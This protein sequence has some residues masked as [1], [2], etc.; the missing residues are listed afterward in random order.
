MELLAKNGSGVRKSDAQK[1]HV[2]CDISRTNKYM[3]KSN[4]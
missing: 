4:T 3:R 1:N 2:M